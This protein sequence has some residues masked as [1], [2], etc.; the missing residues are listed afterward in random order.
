MDVKRYLRGP[1]FWI[2]LALVGLLVVTQVASSG[3]ANK[4]DTPKALQSISDHTAKSVL[5]VD[6]PD[7]QPGYRLLVR[8]QP[9]ELLYPS[10]EH[11]PP[12]VLRRR[13]VVEV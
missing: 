1:I 5:L 10:R 2:L 9:A 7:Q 11:Q 3:G 12:S 8:I 4:V 13:F 6:P